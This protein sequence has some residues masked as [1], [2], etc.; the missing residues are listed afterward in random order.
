M[1]R[2]STEAVLRDHLALRKADDLDTDIA[3]NYAHSIVM[4]RAERTYRGH[5]GV[6]SCADD[7]KRDLPDATFEYRTVRTERDIGFLEWSGKNDVATI[8]D[9]TDSFLIR[10]GQIQIQ[11]IHYTVRRKSD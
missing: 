1:H 6:R 2:R 7:L 3:R 4:I 9:G 8:E 10:D 11:T 5:D